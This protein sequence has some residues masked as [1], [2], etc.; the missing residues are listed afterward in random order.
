M[1]A[2]EAT[3]VELKRAI[4][5][6]AEELR[7]LLMEVVRRKLNASV[8]FGVQTVLSEMSFYWPAEVRMWR[9]EIT[10]I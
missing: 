4:E 5:A 3:D 7:L 2:N 8:R 9:E 1:E 10:E 6:A